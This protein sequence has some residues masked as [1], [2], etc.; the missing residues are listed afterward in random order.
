M[1]MLRKSLLLLAFWGLGLPAAWAMELPDLMALLAQNQ[2]GEARFVEQRWVNG[3][4]QPLQSSG[5]LSF[6]APSRFS[7]VT[8]EPSLES[9]SVE[10]RSVTLKRAGRSRTLSLDAVPEVAAIVEAVRGTLTGDLSTLQQYFNTTFS[11][12]TQQ[13]VLVLEPLDARLAAQ[14]SQVRITGEHRD[15]RTVEIRL[16]DGDSSL[17]RIEPVK[18]TP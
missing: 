10:G 17:M 16:A 11:G 2:R 9:M 5:T 4:T 18:L 15:L 12:Q 13:W 7:R 8:L 14:V 6:V 3:L 1:K